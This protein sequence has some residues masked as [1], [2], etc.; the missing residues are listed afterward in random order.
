[1][2]HA[3]RKYEPFPTHRL[4]NWKILADVF[5]HFLFFGIKIKMVSQCHLSAGSLMMM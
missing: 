5:I 1:M 2:K 3:V 4:G